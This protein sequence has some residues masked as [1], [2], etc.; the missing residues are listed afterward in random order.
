MD[1]GTETGPEYDSKLAVPTA[2]EEESGEPA[3]SLRGGSSREGIIESGMRECQGRV[4]GPS[5]DA[6]KLGFAWS[7]L[8]SKIRSLKIDK[9]RF[10]PHRGT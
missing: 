6:A 7:T 5:G 1:E 3:L 9:N 2:A 10:R 4:F 8:E